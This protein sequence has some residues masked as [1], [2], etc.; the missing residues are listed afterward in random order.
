MP[1]AILS[2]SVGSLLRLR[3]EFLQKVNVNVSRSKRFLRVGLRRMGK[4]G[5]ENGRKERREIGDYFAAR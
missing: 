3:D 2:S 4:K 5:K 1:I